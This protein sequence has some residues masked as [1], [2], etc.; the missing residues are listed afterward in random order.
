MRNIIVL[1]AVLASVPAYAGENCAFFDGTGRHIVLMI[2][3]AQ[4]FTV[5]LAD[6]STGDVCSWEAGGVFC[7]SGEKAPIKV[8]DDN[9]FEFDGV[10]W[11]FK[12]YEPT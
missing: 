1:L 9:H 7:D 2:G 4:E 10:A 11:E 3:E 6:G 8:V 12:C 5:T